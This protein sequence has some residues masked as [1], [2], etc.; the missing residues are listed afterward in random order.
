[1]FL[2]G[3]W[4]SFM[5]R[6]A[7]FID[8]AYLDVIANQ[9]QH[10]R[11]DL[12]IL[13]ERVAGGIEILRTYYYDAPPYQ[14]DPPTPDEIQRTAAKDKRFAKLE[15][16]P[17]FTVRRGTCVKRGSIYIQK[18]VDVLLACDLLQLS[19]KKLI[20]H[21]ALVTGDSDFVPA[22]RIAKDEGVQIWLYHGRS[23]RGGSSLW[24]IA[25]RRFLLQDGFLPL[26]GE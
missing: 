5:R 17:D 25:D 26:L 8:G 22:I 1:M 18:M 11:A 9:E 3:R 13:P 12:S 14:S 16:F 24:Q 21:A 19:F 20:T 23:L 2:R 4:I 10:R 6:I 15:Q 7:I